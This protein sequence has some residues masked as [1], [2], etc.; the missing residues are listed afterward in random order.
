MI[1]P[2][3]SSDRPH[4]H[5]DLFGTPKDVVCVAEPHSLQELAGVFVVDTVPGDNHGQIQRSEAVREYS[6]PT[7]RS[8]SPSV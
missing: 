5:I 1:D 2:I 8:R 6:K 4:A 3:R 7:Q